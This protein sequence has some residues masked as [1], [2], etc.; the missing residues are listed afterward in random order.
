M[1][2]RRV[3]LIT[4]D[5]RNYIN[6]TNATY[7]VVSIEV[8][9]TF[10][11][12]ISSFYTL[13]F[14]RHVRERLNKSGIVSQFIPINFL[15]AA[16]FRSLVRTFLEVF[17]GSILW[18]NS[19]EL[20]LIGTPSGHP[21]LTPEHLN[22]L[23]VDGEIK[24]DLRYT[25]FGGAGLYLNRPEVFLAGFLSGPDGLARLS[26]QAPVFRDDL[27][28]LEYVI[29]KQNNTKPETIVNLII[30]NLEPPGL[31]LHEKPDDATLARIQQIRV[32]NLNDLVAM[33]LVHLWTDRVERFDVPKL[34]EAAELNPNNI[35]IRLL[36]ANALRQQGHQAEAQKHV[37]ESL[38]IDPGHQVSRELGRVF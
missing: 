26:G 19:A 3:K 29:A 9:Q 8:G 2:D 18:Y 12:G 23:K 25:Y 27:P 4:E 21:I 24:S 32:W 37:D 35:T 28:S 11:P 31:I 34:Q 16:E 30:Q 13:D 36:L 17:P 5:G 33:S 20:L 10:R 6:N 22:M 1:N 15:D 7:D 38:Q 14:Y